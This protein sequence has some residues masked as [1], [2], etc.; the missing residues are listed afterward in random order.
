M[1]ILRMIC[2]VLCVA[3]IIA[4]LGGRIMN[5]EGDGLEP[6]QS[7]T[8]TVLGYKRD[9]VCEHDPSTDPQY[10]WDCGDW[11]AITVEPYRAWG[12]YPAFEPVA[13]WA[14]WI[15]EIGLLVI[16]RWLTTKLNNE[17]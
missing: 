11:S 1:R 14:Y 3:S 15:V 2:G 17:K 10:P 8:A 7:L 5:K 6:A 4:G 12:I 13:R 16:L 9:T